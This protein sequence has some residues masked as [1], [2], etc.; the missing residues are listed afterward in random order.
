MHINILSLSEIDLWNKHLRGLPFNQHDVYYTPK[1]Y[2][3]FESYE[4]GKAQCFVFEKD[5]DI[6]LYPFLLNSVNDLGYDLDQQYYDIQGAYGYN[7]VVS[8]SYQ[9]N[10]IDSFYGAFN[11]WCQ[12]NNII[13]EFIRFNPYFMNHNFSKDYL[14]Q[15]LNRR[16][17]ILDLNDSFDT[18]WEK[19]FSS[20]TRNMIRKALKNDYTTT[21]DNT[22]KGVRDFYNIYLN[23]MKGIE[24]D[25]YYYFNLN[26]FQKMLNE[27]SFHF[28]F[29]EDDEYSRVATMILMIYGKYAH[30]H[31]SGRVIEKADN[32]VNN[33]LL[34]EAIKVAK[35][36]GAEWFHFGGGNSI[37]ENDSLFRFKKG[38][39]KTYL[40]FYIGKKIHNQKVYSSIHEQWKKKHPNSFNQY[41]NLLLGYRNIKPN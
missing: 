39:S 37:D 9:P 2:S 33:Y 31:L 16:T 36:K 3:L 12:K 38:F 22:D 20:K 29:V 28:L 4:D 13:A 32:S 27:P 24:S 34:Y 1:Y 10:F 14:Q 8:S 30:Y 5:G 25:S 7:G 11:K 23:T 40:D 26:M 18:I 35:H 15:L 21:I 19:A 17:V 6:A 41:K